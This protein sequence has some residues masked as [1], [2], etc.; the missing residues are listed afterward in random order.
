MAT[1][2][3]WVYGWVGVAMASALIGPAWHFV[4]PFSTLHDLGVALVRRLGVTPWEAADFPARLGRWPA[5]VGFAV[6]IW[7]ELVLA[8]GPRVLFVVLV[9]YTAFTLAMMAQFGRDT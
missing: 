8:G 1:L 7:L 5:V 6:V 2:F 3:I 4:D 9:G